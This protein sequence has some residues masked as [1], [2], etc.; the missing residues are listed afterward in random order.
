VRA[1][2]LGAA[3]SGEPD[4]VEATPVQKVELAPMSDP[5]VQGAACL[6][7]AAISMAAAY[8]AGPVEALMLMSGA[9]HVATSPS[10]LFIPMFSILGGGACALAATATPSV[11]WLIDQSGNMGRQW[12]LLMGGWFSDRSEG[13]QGA[14]ARTNGLQDDDSEETPR[15]PTSLRPMTETEL[16][17]T[18]CIIGALAGLGASMATSPMEVAMLS[19][20]ATTI[21]SSTPLLG[22]GLLATIVGA[23]CGIGS[24]VAVPMMAL[25]NH[26]SSRSTSTDTCRTCSP[27]P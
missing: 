12:V 15:A 1:A 18:G 3:S 17:S 13:G 7:F 19:S 9:Q 22:L 25:I 10:I 21:V 2:S 26:F 8:A 11:D 24:F 23:S 4:R 14:S 27:P 16:Q 20:G 6:G 5:A